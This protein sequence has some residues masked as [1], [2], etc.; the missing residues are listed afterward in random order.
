MAAVVGRKALKF[1]PVISTLT[2]QN[3]RPTLCSAKVNLFIIMK[4]MAGHSHW[5]NIKFKKA[6]IDFARSKM[7]GRLT[8]E[9]M[10]AV[11]GKNHS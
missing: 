2:N 3:I 9:I 6:H 8:A 11:R 4:R 1:T 10:T 7:F 5:A